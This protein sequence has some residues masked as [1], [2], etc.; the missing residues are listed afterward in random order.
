MK[1]W[2]ELWER[3]VLPNSLETGKKILD[4]VRTKCLACN[5]QLKMFDLPNAEEVIFAY[6][7]HDSLFSGADLKMF[8][9]PNAAEVVS[10]YIQSILSIILYQR[11]PS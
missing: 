1:A 8:D 11:M 10:E 9:L 2:I 4:Y 5:L 6:I 7:K 3:G